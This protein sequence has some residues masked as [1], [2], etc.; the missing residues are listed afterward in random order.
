MNMIIKPPTLSGL[1]IVDADTHIAEVYDLWTSRAP[2]KFKARVPQVK[3]VNGVAT[4][5]IDGDQVMGPANPVCCI[6]ADGSKSINFELT[7]WKFEDAFK[8]SWEVNARLDYMDSVGIQAQIAYPNLLGFGNQKAM[9]VDAELRLVTTQIYNDAMAE[10]QRDSG[11]RIFPMALL[12]WWDMKEMLAECK[13]THDLGLRGINT[14]SD[15]QNNGLPPL[16]DKHWD[17]IWNLCQDLDT[18]VNFHIGG[19]FSSKEWFGD[20]GWDKT[21]MGVNV[22]FGSSTMFV[23]NYKSLANIL[24]SR[25]LERFP[26]LKVVSVESGVGWI[27]FMLESLEYFMR[28]EKIPYKLSP[29]EIFQRQMYACCWFE[30]AMLV[31][32]TRYLGVDNVM[33]QT[34]FPHPVCQ[35]PDSLEF[36]EKAAAG[37][38]PEE[39]KKVMGTNAAK[40]YN[41]PLA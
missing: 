24:L 34:D 17:P 33:I 4:W 23:S 31:E 15:P 40:V 8:G 19:G 3:D 36:M 14:H 29:R 6:R 10:M 2:A 11:N 5:V 41:I 30:K 26:T 37:F 20:G 35:Y 9:G 22:A 13:R 7:K 18:P 28:E 21:D 1:S 12:P 39:R 38:T 16:S 27:P 32:T 25:M